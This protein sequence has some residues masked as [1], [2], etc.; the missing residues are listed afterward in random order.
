M[1]KSGV[2]KTLFLVI[3]FLLPLQPLAALLPFPITQPS[4][5]QPFDSIL[6][7]TWSGIKK[8]NI[9]A[10]AVPLVHRPKS[11]IPGDAVSEGVGYGLLVSLY[12]NDQVYFNKIWD[13][14]EQYMWAGSSYNW[15]VDINGSV[16]GSGPATDAEEDI[17]V[18]RRPA[19]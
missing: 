1:P 12:C 9:D 13:A 4:V 7:K 15:R 2:N 11:E 5:T 10:Y 16:I 18:A 14:A 17:T 6:L 19:R 3:L 8:R